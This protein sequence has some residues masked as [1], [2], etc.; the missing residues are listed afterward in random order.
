MKRFAPFLYFTLAAFAAIAP[1]YA[2]K[3]SSCQNPFSLE[4][5]WQES[6]EQTA[7]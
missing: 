4:S 6:N 3:Q 1:F 7:A 5:D 2:A